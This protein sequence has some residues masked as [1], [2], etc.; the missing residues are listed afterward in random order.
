MLKKIKN[1]F[2]ECLNLHVAGATIRHNGVFSKLDT[3]Q[4]KIPLNPEF[5]KKYVSP[6][7]MSEPSD[8]KYKDA[9]ADIKDDVDLTIITNLLGE[10]NWRPRTV[11]AYFAAIENKHGLENNIGNLLLRS[12]V[13][14]AGHYYCLALASFASENSVVFLKKYLDY[15]LTQYD[16][17][18]DQASAMAALFY[19]SEKVDKNL[20]SVYLPSWRKFIKNKKNW[21]L[22]CSINA[23]KKQMMVLDE[24]KHG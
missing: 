22:E 24:Y 4:N 17:W 7:Y 9:Y 15:Y 6:F 12:D 2:N 11:G 23:F 8:I 1:K 14:Y 19:L 20:Y 13:C 18:F 5:I 16:L 21:D 3:F 10:C